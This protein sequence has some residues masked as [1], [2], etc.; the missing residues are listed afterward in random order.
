MNDQS[1]AQTPVDNTQRLHNAFDP[2]E[3]HSLRMIRESYHPGHDF[4]TPIE[5]ARLRFM[6]W[7]FRA[8]AQLVRSS[9]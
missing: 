4:F 9:C 1:A 2:D 6:R 5:L 3:L 8:D 7:L